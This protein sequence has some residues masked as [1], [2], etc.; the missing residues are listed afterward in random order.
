VRYYTLK[1]AVV[2]LTVA[3]LIVI[4][5]SALGLFHTAVAY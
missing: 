5:L 2:A 3:V 1:K 4:A